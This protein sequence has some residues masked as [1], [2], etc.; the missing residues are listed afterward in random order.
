[1]HDDRVLVEGRIARELVQR[2][3][4]AIHPVSVPLMVEA[5]V[6]PGEP[7]PFD[8]ARR[9]RFEP[10]EVGGR[11]GRPWGTTWF[12]CTGAVPPEWAGSGELVVD[13]GFDPRWPGFQAEGL[14]RAADGRVLGSLHP[15]RTTLPLDVVGDGS[16][17]EVFIEAAS[18]PGL[19]GSYAPSPMGRWDTAPDRPLYTLRTAALG[20][21]D[22][23]VF[24]LVMD[25]EVL[26][27]LMRTLEPT[28]PR[29]QRLLR[30]LEGA[31]DA[32]RLTD[33]AG[34][35]AA[36]RAVLAPALA[37]PARASA[38]RMVAVGHA[39]IDTAWLWP[40][41]ETVRKCIR[42]FAGAVE[43]M[44]RYPEYRFACSQAAQYDWIADREPDLFERIRSKVA[45][46]Q[47][48]PVGGM[49]VE[50][51]MNLPS[52]ESLVRQLVH[53]QRA[54]ERWFGRRCSEVWIPDVFGYPASLPQVFALAGCTRFVTQKLS[55]NKQNRFPHH[56]FWWEGLDGTR[57][58]AHFPPVETYNAELVPAE[59]DHAVRTF[60]DHG[61]SD[62]SL[63]PFGHGNGGGGPTQEML[64]RARR[65]RDLD[66]APRVQVGTVEEFFGHLEA[67]VAA[68]APVPV[69]RGEL[70]FEMHRGTLTS[71]LR[72]KVG[73]RHCERLLRE[74]ELVWAVAGA[75]PTVTSQF[76]AWWKSL[77]VQQFHDIL[78]GSSIGWVHD[79]A[80]AEFGRLAAEVT[81]SIE[82]A[83]RHLA[84]GGGAVVNARTHDADEVV[85]VDGEPR[86]VVAPG[87]GV[88]PLT[89]PAADD[90]V[91]VTGTSL[92]NGFLHVSLDEHGQLA[93]VT[94]LVRGRELLAPGT[95]GAVLETAPDHPVEYDAWDVEAWARRRSVAVTDATV[96]VAC[97]HPLLGEVRVVRR[98]GASSA[99]LTYRLRAGSARL[100][101][102][103]DLDWRE[104]ETLLSLAFPLAP[105]AEQA[106]CAIQFGHVRRPTHPSTPWDA[107]KFE[108]CAHGWVD[109]SEPSFGVAVLD[110]GRYGHALFDGAVRV[111]L[112]RAPSYPDPVADRGHHRCTVALLP[113]G[114]GLADVIR[115]AE[116][117]ELPLRVV[118]GERPIPV[119]PT[120]ATGPTAP[121]GP[122]VLDGSVRV[123]AVK[124]ADDGSG[125]VIVRAHEAL[126]DHTVVALRVGERRVRRAAL[127]EEPAEDLPV[128]E[129]I[130]RL[131]LRP[132]E[133]V[134]LRLSS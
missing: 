22:H 48:L 88:G 94:D 133:I 52:G 91:V 37:L 56:T 10:F 47:W 114:P 18:N 90:R 50:A 1:M 16:A 105:R 55:W 64:E 117:L 62:W 71:Q 42:T 107:A 83:L 131:P 8:Q 59:L 9:L 102:D 13:L 65:V 120:A 115:E 5:A 87:L 85:V 75:P 121:T 7:V 73:N 3:F 46:G 26:D 134:T 34:T 96:A 125:D 99:T 40:M 17:V 41:R 44:D 119:G 60:R 69:F 29:R 63:V 11:W 113:H 39:H 127:T 36:A 24:G 129:G 122:R 77:L 89:L 86:R 128:H 123:T 109:V 57:V 104:D 101:V 49:W 21:R 27:Q 19:G 98:F 100:D 82:E 110:D 14:V 126:G 112:A 67:E 33:V 79:D 111:T 70:Y 132:F 130:V 66:G 54:F 118:P 51:D 58:L 6:L 35:A 53:G 116:A 93:S 23:E 108:V 45:G 72:T 95:T 15:R 124:P 25:V 28:D 4:P 103:V 38:H 43:L 84:P 68:G 81:A 97:D 106:T 76:D 78:P 20:R 80:E 12:R 74:A 31:L 30:T 61:W 2:L 92:R 32:L